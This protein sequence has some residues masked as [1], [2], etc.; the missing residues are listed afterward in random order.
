MEYRSTWNQK[1]WD[2]ADQFYWAPQ[3]IG[4]KSIPRVFGTKMVT[5][6]AY[7]RIM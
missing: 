6:S 2:I 4:M 5:G 7:L 1:Y 3:Y